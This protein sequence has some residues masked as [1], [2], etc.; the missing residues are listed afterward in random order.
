LQKAPQLTKELYSGKL[1][2]AATTWTL[3]ALAHI[4]RENKGD[5]K[6]ILEYAK[7]GSLNIRLQ[8][9]RALGLFKV[10]AAQSSFVETLKD[11]EPRLR[12]AALLGLQKVGFGEHNEAIFAALANETD[13]VCNYTAFQVMRRVFSIDERKQHYEAQSGNVEEIF[14]LALMEDKALKGSTQNS[15]AQPSVT[16]S[17]SEVNWRESTEVTFDLNNVS[18][19]MQARYTLDGSKPTSKSAKYTKPFNYLT[20]PKAYNANMENI[21]KSHLSSWSKVNVLSPYYFFIDSKS[22]YSLGNK[23]RLIAITKSSIGGHHAVAF[24]DGHIEAI[25]ESKAISLILISLIHRFKATIY[26]Q[27]TPSFFVREEG[28]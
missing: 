15:A 18:R 13:R 23:N 4:E 11:K 5:F 25:K 28:T 8:A 12:H 3:W 26:R 19:K 24:E 22:E 27:K 21:N 16:L 17:L 14:E 7:S 6:N 9:I 2:T 10:T 1:S 20:K